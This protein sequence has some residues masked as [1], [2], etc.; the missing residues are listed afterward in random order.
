MKRYPKKQLLIDDFL[1]L[2][3]VAIVLII[4]IPNLSLPYFW[5]EAWSYMTAIN[6]MAEVGPSLLPGAIPLDYCKGHPQLF[7]FLGAAWLKIKPGSIL[8]MRILP[9]LFSIGLLLIVYFFIKKVVDRQ[10][11]WAATLLISVQS[12]FIAQSILVLPEVLF[13]LFLVAALFSLIRGNHKAYS[14]WGSL[15]VLTKETAIIY[16]FIA[17]I[18]HLISSLKNNNK[19]TFSLKK[20]FLVALPGIV[21]ILFLLLHYTSFGVF[22]YPDHLNYVD[23][24]P[25]AFLKRFGS[26]FTT[27]FVHYGRILLFVGLVI[28]YLIQTFVFK[29]RVKNPSALLLLIVSMFSFLIFMSFNF[30]SPRY[31][32]NLSILLCII[33]ALVFYQLS[34]PNWLKQTITISIASICIF[35]SLQTKRNIDIDLGYVEVIKV[36]KEMVNYFEQNNLYEQPI[37]LSFNLYHAMSDT[38]LGYLENHKTFENAKGLDDFKRTRYF[39][40][41]S[42]TGESPSVEF[43][44]ANFKL[45]KTFSNKHAWGFI[46]ENPHPEISQNNN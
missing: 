28:S 26:A 25:A 5:D 6:K 37:S 33:F 29:I 21:W 11:A 39:A 35:F 20:L 14:V 15:M 34:T 36:N 38:R 46:Y 40:F 24:S 27:A 16:L 41:E 18:F 45:I 42:T 30:Y 3:P 8:L 2:I 4:Q 43:V 23:L 32:L 7:C 12:T 19:E 9:L 22:F 44:K 1:I 31:T 17:G 10:T 13:S